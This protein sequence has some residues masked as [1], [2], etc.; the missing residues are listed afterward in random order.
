M[1]F[2]PCSNIFV[3]HPAIIGLQK[4]N[5]LHCEK[6]LP[7]KLDVLYPA[8]DICRQLLSLPLETLNVVADPPV[9][10]TIDL[11]PA[12][13]MLGE[14]VR[15]VQSK[16]TIPS[17]QVSGGSYPNLCVCACFPDDSH[18]GPY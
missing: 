17:E 12:V 9:Y 11:Y 13:R 10:P 16:R 7:V 8:F 1:S 15:D 5:G 14:S 3:I 6:S 18:S 4:Q 2:R